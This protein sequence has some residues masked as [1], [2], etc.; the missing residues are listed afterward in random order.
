[1]WYPSAIKAHDERLTVNIDSAEFEPP[2]PGQRSG[3]GAANPSEEA[4]ARTEQSLRA[5]V[6]QRLVHAA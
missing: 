2:G 3:S 1:M 5:A 4:V 6:M